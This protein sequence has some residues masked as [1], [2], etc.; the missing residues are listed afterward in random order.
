MLKII[1]LRRIVTL[2]IAFLSINTVTILRMSF[3]TLINPSQSQPSI[4]LKA[5]QKTGF[6]LRK[7][8]CHI[9]AFLQIFNR[10]ITFPLYRQHVCVMH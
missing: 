1:I 5:H 9:I 6:S 7:L 4:P 3:S 10:T 2:L 8:G